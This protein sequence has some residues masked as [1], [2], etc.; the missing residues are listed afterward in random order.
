VI[1]FLLLLLGLTAIVAVR[2]TTRWLVA[3]SFGR[4][5]WRSPLRE[6]I[7]LRRPPGA[8]LATLAAGV[9][10]SYLCV[11][12]VVFANITIYGAPDPDGDSWTAVV[13]TLEG[14][15]AHGK[16]QPG[17]RILAADGVPV[18]ERPLGELVN[19]RQGEPVT[20]TVSSSGQTRDVVVR[21]K[22]VDSGGNPTWRIGVQLGREF[23]MLSTSRGALSA[24]AFPARFTAEIANG[25]VAT[26]KDVVDPP[27][28]EDVGGPVRI[29]TE[30]Q[31]A[32]DPMGQVLLR[33]LASFGSALLIVL[34]VLDLARVVVLLRGDRTA[35][36]SG[37]SL[38]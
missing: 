28:A 1:Y 18:V 21:P 35:P 14:Y 11:S 22:L 33:T 9:A 37:S 8:R 20:L 12:A 36:G 16:L 3:R 25:L 15:D 26:V 17:D 6:L 34:V 7:A 32:L 2:E 29:V 24:L 5:P 38:A 19:Q 30:F 13:G 4:S 10:A 23:T 31:R 27:A